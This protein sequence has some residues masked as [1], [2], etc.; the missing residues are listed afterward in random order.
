MMM[1]A[2]NTVMIT[3]IIIIALV[4]AQLEPRRGS[5]DGRR[6]GET[7]EPICLRPLRQQVCAGVQQMGLAH[8]GAQPRRPPRPSGETGG[9]PPPT[10]S[11]GGPSQDGAR[12]EVR[13]LVRALRDVKA[14]PMSDIVGCGTRRCKPKRGWPIC[15]CA[16]IYIYI[17][18]CICIYIYIYIYI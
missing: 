7:R 10:L 3:T 5:V 6:R 17:Y 4:A 1:I 14:L 18:V 9:S 16:Y 8:S 12:D 2:V 11:E 13:I 15:I